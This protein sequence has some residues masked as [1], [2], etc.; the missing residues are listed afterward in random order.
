LQREQYFPQNAPIS[1][2]EIPVR[3][4]ARE[5]RLNRRYLA[6]AL[7]EIVAKTPSSKRAIRVIPPAALA[8]TEQ[9]YYIFL[10][11][12]ILNGPGEEERRIVR[13]DMLEACLLITRL[14][15]PE[16]KHVVGIAIDS[17]LE[18]F[19]RSEDV[20]YFDC[21]DW[22]KAHEEEAKMLEMELGFFINLAQQERTITE[23]PL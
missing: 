23:F 1:E 17:G 20:A 8:A 21:S 7:L 11:L 19:G 4:L 5:S 6:D 12:P 10:L 3:I 22:D 14:K 9:L 18:N 2:L 15:F 13:R 16:A